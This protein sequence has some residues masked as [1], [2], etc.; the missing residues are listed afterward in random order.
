MK[1]GIE[2][3]INKNLQK[4]SV[5]SSFLKTNSKQDNNLEKGISISNQLLFSAFNKNNFHKGN[6][7][8]IV[9]LTSLIE[10]HFSINNK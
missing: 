5:K 9:L 10:D 3:K 6:C 8:P 2:L 1:K 4:E 7:N